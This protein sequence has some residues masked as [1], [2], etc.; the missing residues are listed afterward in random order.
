MLVSEKA[1]VAI[2]PSSLGAIEGSVLPVGGEL[3]PMC[4]C[5]FAEAVGA[6]PKSKSAVHLRP[7]EVFAAGVG[8]PPT[9]PLPV[10]FVGILDDDVV[11]SPLDVSIVGLV[12]AATLSLP[13]LGI[14]A[15]EEDTVLIAGI[16]V[17]EPPSTLSAIPADAVEVPRVP[18]LKI[19]APRL[20]LVV[21]ELP[22]VFIVEV[23]MP[24][25]VL[26]LVELPNMFVVESD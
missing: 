6:L 12:T 10:M 14:G 8:A 4:S 22:N 9:L 21:V 5:M 26:V 24:K 1:H 11:L 3:A 20:P 23:D 18:E 19:D 25:L 15:F 7:L 16:G 13:L 17:F 2:V